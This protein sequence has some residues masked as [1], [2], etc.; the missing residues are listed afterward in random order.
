MV[1]IKQVAETAG[2]SEATVSRVLNDHPTVD[3][4]LRQRVLET[5]A[6]LNYQ[7]S[8]VA[9]SL[10]RQRTY[11]I[12]LIVPDNRNPFYAEIARAA[13]IFC[14]EAGYSVYLCNSDEDERKEID[15]CHK[16]H[17]QRVDGV[18]AAITGISAEAIH[19]LKKHRMPVVLVDR[20]HPEV[21]ADI[22]QSDHYQGACDALEYLIEL[23]HRRVA[24]ISGEKHEP[25][26][27]ERLKAYH[28]VL[29]KHRRTFDPTMIYESSGNKRPEFETGYAGGRYLLN[30]PDRPTAIFAFND[31]I[32]T[33]AL[34]YAV[35]QGIGVP[36]E[37]SIVGVDN[38]PL[39]SFISPRLTTV[40][41]SML[42]LGRSAAELLLRRIQGLSEGCI[43]QRLPS[44]LLIRESTGKPTLG[45]N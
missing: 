9:R 25:P 12:G 20:G 26:I 18:I 29:H 28:D 36:H 37:L 1:T 7:P 27:Q 35:E 34:R 14:G 19:Y 16:L 40:A 42:E 39:S 6:A 44:P 5:I 32:A 38:I 17:Q 8:G 21:Q 45:K 2:V 43:Q 3:P 31:T 24:V 11:T 15:Y 33:G 30:R 22:I 13:E 10:R 41:Q 23:G 4:A